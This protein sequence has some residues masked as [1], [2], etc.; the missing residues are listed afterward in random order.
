MHG[1]RISGVQFAYPVVWPKQYPDH[2]ID[3][4]HFNGTSLSAGCGAKPRS[5]Q[6]GSRAPKIYASRDILLSTV[7][8]LSISFMGLIADTLGIRMVYIAGSIC[9]AI[10]AG[11]SFALLR[12]Q[13]KSAI[14]AEKGGVFI[15][16]KKSRTIG[17]GS[18]ETDRQVRSFKI[19]E[20]INFGGCRLISQENYR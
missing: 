20:R 17:S 6:C 15:T 5:I 7:T 1:G 14:V 3:P 12:L 9:I 16:C 4:M 2:G 10:S 18:W 11:L 19:A 13:R 8:S